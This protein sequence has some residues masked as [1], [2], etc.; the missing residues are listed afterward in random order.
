MF[1]G[2]HAQLPQVCT[3]EVSCAP[4][5]SITR[6]HAHFVSSHLVFPDIACS[7]CHF[8]GDR[9]LWLVDSGSGF[10][11]L[12]GFKH[13]VA[14][15]ESYGR[16]EWVQTLPNGD[17]TVVATGRGGWMVGRQTFH[18][19]A[20]GG[21]I[22]HPVPLEPTAC[23]G[24]LFSRQHSRSLRRMQVANTHYRS[25]FYQDLFDAAGKLPKQPDYEDMSA[26]VQD[27]RFTGEHSS[28]GSSLMW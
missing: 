5:L 13:G 24:D 10:I 11:N 22:D 21:I 28:C 2:H 3:Q 15:G 4:L 6:S 9:R 20:S 16:I 26:L 7:N 19:S 1:P 12:K 14:C 23:V 27:C 8:R 17:A 18:L 25:K